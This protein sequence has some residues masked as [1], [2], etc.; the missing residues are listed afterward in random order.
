MN[1][2][3]SIQK[4]VP[5]T[6]INDTKLYV[7]RQIADELQARIDELLVTAELL[8]YKCETYHYLDPMSLKKYTLF[9]GNNIIIEFCFN[10]QSR[11]QQIN[12]ILNFRK[13]KVK[14][15]NNCK[16]FPK[17]ISLVT[18]QLMKGDNK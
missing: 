4:Y 7:Q 14:K 18:Q 3:N 16:N 10:K 2:Q 8:D 17:L 13:G 1:L 6:I 12:A 11:I 5:I 9:I 15:E